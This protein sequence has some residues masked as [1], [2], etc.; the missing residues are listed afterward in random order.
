MSKRVEATTGPDGTEYR[1]FICPGCKRAVTL[2]VTGPNA[3]GF[4]RD[5][6]NPTF[7]PSI[8]QKTFDG[9]NVCHSFV[10]DGRIRFLTDSAHSLSG[11]TVELDAVEE[12][13]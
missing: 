1:S 10:T 5:D 11:Q 7:T 9:R 12:K 4:N 13:E 8:L 2:P 6:S 3:W